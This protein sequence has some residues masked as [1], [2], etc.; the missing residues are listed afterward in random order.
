LSGRFLR[1]RIRKGNDTGYETIQLE[2][3]QLFEKRQHRTTASAIRP[4]PFFCRQEVPHYCFVVAWTHKHVNPVLVPEFDA[5]QDGSFSGN[6]RTDEIPKNGWRFD[7]T[8]HLAHNG[9]KNAGA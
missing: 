9:E 4:G 6:R 5:N 8:V 2:R 7:G 3:T 1:E